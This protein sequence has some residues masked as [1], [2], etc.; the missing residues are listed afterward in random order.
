MI[1][2]FNKN[3]QWVAL[4]GLCA[5]LP[6]LAGRSA[7][8]QTPA[9]TAFTYQGQ[10]KNGGDPADGSF[11][12]AFSLYDGPDPLV[13]AQIASTVE[14]LDVAVVD[15]LF[16]VELDF[17]SDA[18][19]G[20]ARWLAIAVRPAGTGSFVDLL[21]LQPVTAAPHAQFAL[22]VGPGPCPSGYVAAN[23]KFCIQQSEHTAGDKTWYEAVRI[24]SSEDAHVCFLQ[25]WHAACED[26]QLGMIDMTNDWE[27]F[28]DGTYGVTFFGVVGNGNCRVLTATTGTSY[29]NPFRC[30]FDR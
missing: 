14:K 28:G 19:R 5:V 20:D 8:G 4:L 22:E 9:G 23:T 10:L 25:E 7:G 29:S 18:F 24:C 16:T 30:C 11:D 2:G 17:G 3:L 21:P 12:L 6:A 26:P 15:G 1:E 13:D 27:Y